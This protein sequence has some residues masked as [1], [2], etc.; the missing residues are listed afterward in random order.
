MIFLRNVLRAPVRSLL[1]LLGVAGGVALFVAISTITADLRTQIAHAVSAYNLE[2]V[3]Y[4]RRATSAFS[5]RI[6]QAQ[7]AAL[8]ARFGS[9]LTPMVLGSLNEKWN[10]YALVV[11]A[12]ADFSRRIP[13][14]AG[15]H[16]TAGQPEVMVGEI[17]AQ[18]LQ[19]APGKRIMLD[20]QDYLIT[21]IYR[22]GSRLLDG[23]VMG[24][25]TDVQQM[26]TR[27][28]EEGRYTLALLQTT[29]PQARERFLQEVAEHFPQLRAV[30]GTEFAGSLR[31][32][33]VVNAFVTA[34]SILVLIGTVLV[35]T[36]TLV[37]AVAERT[38]EIGILMTVGWT[39][40]RVLRMLMAESLLLC[41]L[42]AAAGQGL[43]LL[44]LHLLNR[45]ESVGYGWIPV[46]LS[47]SVMADAAAMSFVVAL[48][49]LLWPA[50][51]LWR[52]QPLHA[53]RHE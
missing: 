30:P 52:I 29:N 41:S 5:S 50:I 19:L 35:V 13:L 12:G 32:L 46:K 43:A 40:W 7:M 11:G 3:V 28:G 20:G 10:A 16:F 22:T 14:V 18:R 27:P 37:M 36:N 6:T 21:G 4:E 45:M 9:A 42:G 33:R 15:Q 49:S 25:I 53:L 8:S 48:F 17:N 1:T 31:L 34:I 26:L 47:W 23:G 2:V 39:P 44:L 24:S 51:V 38:R